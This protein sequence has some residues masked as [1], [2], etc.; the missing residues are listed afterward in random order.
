MILNRNTHTQSH[1]KQT[2]NN[3]TQNTSSAQPHTHNTQQQM[4]WQQLQQNTIKL[5]HTQ[6]QQ[7][8]NDC[9]TIKTINK[10]NIYI[11]IA[12]TYTHLSDKQQQTNTITHDNY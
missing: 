6:N 2:H 10:N 7:Q 5:I 12:C 9:S 4:Q 3:T 11:H 1:Y 8:Y